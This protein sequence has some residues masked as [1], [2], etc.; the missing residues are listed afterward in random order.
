MS[1]IVGVG[2]MGV[3][4]LTRLDLRGVTDDLRSQFP[5]PA[6]ATE[7]PIAEVRAILNEVR[8]AATTPSGA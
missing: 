1:A 3:S 4:M 7:P 6:A 5:R 8:M 2:T